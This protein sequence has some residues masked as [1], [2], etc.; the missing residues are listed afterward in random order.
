MES[1]EGL[2]SQL[3]ETK[4]RVNKLSEE[5]EHWLLE[6]QLIQMKL[7]QEKKVHKK[8]SETNLNKKKDELLFPTPKL[9]P[10]SSFAKINIDLCIMKWMKQSSLT[11]WV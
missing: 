2:S 4:A 8:G 10:T 7:E 5:K 11:T 9:T 6:A 3:L 1:K